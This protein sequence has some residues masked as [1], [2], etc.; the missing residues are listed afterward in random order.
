[1][2]SAPANRF[3]S[4]FAPPLSTA[5]GPNAPPSA[6]AP[7]NAAANISHFPMTIPAGP[8]T[9]MM[10]N[11]FTGMPTSFGSSY[12]SIFGPPEQSAFDPV[13]V[14]D[15]LLQDLG[16]ERT[17]AFTI[18]ARPENQAQSLEELRLADYQAGRGRQCTYDFSFGFPTAFQPCGFKVPGKGLLHLQLP[19]SQRSARLQYRYHPVTI[20]TCPDLG[21][22]TI[23]IN[24]GGSE[25]IPFQ[26]F[27]VHENA[28][29]P[30]AEFV[31]MALTG[32]WKE[33]TERTIPLSEDEPAVFHVYQTW[34]YTRRIDT[35][36]P[37]ESFYE[38][39]IKC[40]ILGEKLLDTTFKDAIMDHIL[41]RISSS[42]LFQSHL[43]SLV[44]KGTPEG[45]PLRR[46]MCE[47][48]AW[49]G[50]STWFDEGADGELLAELARLQA[51]FWSGQRPEQVPF[52]TADVCLYHGHAKGV[53]CY[54][55]G[56]FPKLGSHG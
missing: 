30:V 55:W 56:G 9:T 41:D 44:Y 54:R 16:F 47:L 22:S 17:V 8:F 43:S 12:P 42:Q 26:R 19:A 49:C 53:W 10:Q 13:R 28:V 14:T 5:A 33:A 45:S 52:L 36:S 46:L 3:T 35:G 48:F 51:G 7:P 21:T 27:V 15:P 32:E 34:L 40:Y 18:T 25:G 11:A 2:A 6:T 29:R 50:T 4:L 31:K 38:R 20:T 24:V 37:D 1:M 39:L 23:V